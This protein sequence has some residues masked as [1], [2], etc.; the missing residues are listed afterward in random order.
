MIGAVEQFNNINPQTI[1][2]YS[3]KTDY[4]Q[5]LWRDAVFETGARFSHT[6]TD[7]DLT[8]KVF[9]GNNWQINPDM[10]NRFVYAEQINAAYLN[11]SQQL[12]NFQLQGGLR[13]EYTYAKGEQKPT[14]EVN[15]TTYF[16]L[17][18]T[19]FVNYRASRHIFGLSYS[20][21]LS[22]PNFFHLNPF[23]VMVDAFSFVKGNPYLMPAYTHNLQFSYTLGGLMTRFSYANTTGFITQVPIV[24]EISQRTGII[25][26][27]FERSQNFSA[28]VNYRRQLFNIWT[29][30]LMTQYA[31]VINT[32]D[33]AT[34]EF[35]NRGSTFIANFNNNFTI[36]PTLSAEVTGL[37]VA[38]IRQGYFVVA[39]FGNLSVG[40]RQTLL[41]N[42]MALS[43]N[44]NDILFTDRANTRAQF[45]NVNNT[46]NSG[47]DS[48]FVHLTV[49]YNFGS[50]TVRAAR[51]RQTGIED[52]AARAR[53]GQ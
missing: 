53:G 47:R 32:S 8:H 24:D 37:Y 48:R 19:F 35:I 27:N 31:Y 30:N 16:N 49:R 26:Q 36:T 23:E 33:E 51:Q 14:G 50:T 9:V 25:W 28:M 15:D 12:G 20:R 43:L 11:V 46:I 10:S 18:P 4:T 3:A 6:V 29:A 41:N 7:N 2:V 52:E 44:V 13:A 42:R 38:G 5:P 39:P 45:E 22:R 21:R 1:S 17:F 34:S 40:I